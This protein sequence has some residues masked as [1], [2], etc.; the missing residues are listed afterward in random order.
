[1]LFI[2]F[3]YTAFLFVFNNGKEFKSILTKTIINR[4]LYLPLV[5]QVFIIDFIYVDRNIVFELSK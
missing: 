3:T 4:A 2:F 5:M 1:M